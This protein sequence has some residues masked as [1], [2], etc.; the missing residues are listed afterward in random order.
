MPGFGRNAALAPA[1]RVGDVE[2]RQAR[3]LVLL[4]RGPDGRVRQLPNCGSTVSG[5]LPGAGVGRVERAAGGQREVP[6]LPRAREVLQERPAH[7]ADRV[8]LV[9][10]DAAED[11]RGRRCRRTAPRPPCSTGSRARCRR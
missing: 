9:Q 8:H 11:V 4:D 3:R 10:V 2:V 6:V 1:T 7:R 5:W